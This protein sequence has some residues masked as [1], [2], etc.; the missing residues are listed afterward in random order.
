[1]PRPGVIAVTRP[2]FDLATHYGSAWFSLVIDAARRRGFTVVDLHRGAATRVEVERALASMDPELFT[3]VGHGSASV[4]TGHLLDPIFRACVNDGQLR[5]R[6]VYLLSCLTG[7][8]LGPSMV[9]KGCRAYVGYREVYGFV[10]D[11]R[12]RDRPLEDPYAR[13]FMEQ[14]NAI[15]LTLIDGGTV[16]EAVQ[17]SI[18]VAG[19]WIRYWERQGTRVGMLVAMWLR[20]N[21]GALTL[22]GDESARIAAPVRLGLRGPLALAAVGAVAALSTVLAPPPGRGV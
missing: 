3:G 7:R 17:R 20:H 12:Y 21:I 16:G 6:V 1:M 13:A 8:R 2:D 18:S 14:S 9:R 10:I 11:L 4:F 5:D 19:R 22:L 15:P